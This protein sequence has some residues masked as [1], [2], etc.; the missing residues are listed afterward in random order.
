MLNL[1]LSVKVMVCFELGS[2]I[3]IFN[4]WFLD[5]DNRG[6]RNLPIFQYHKIEKKN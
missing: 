6:G 5:F 4:K 3:S 1:R 2:I